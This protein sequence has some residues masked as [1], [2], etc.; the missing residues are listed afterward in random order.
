MV[1]NGVG[2][3]NTFLV[4]RGLNLEVILGNDFL[5]KH[6]AVIDFQ[7]RLL[8]LNNDVEPVQIS[9]ERVIDTVRIAGVMVIL[10]RVS[11][12]ETEVNMCVCR[13]SEREG[14]MSEERIWEDRA[15]KFCSEGGVVGSSQR[16]ALWR[17]VECFRGVFAD[18]PG[19]A[20]NY[21]CELKVREYAPYVQR[22]YPV[23]YSKRK[24]VQVE[25]D[26][27]LEGDIIER[28]VSP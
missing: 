5:I 27:M 11:K 23:P 4:V 7:K 17:V 24:A 2:Y 14:D 6:K 22:S 16:E 8:L 10:N 21:E 3:D 28:S 9:F 13:E 1:I 26:K 15:V 18:I 20:R 19:R 12:L 25:L